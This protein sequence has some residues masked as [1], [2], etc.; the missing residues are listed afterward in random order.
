MTAAARILLV[1]DEPQIVR[2][3]TPTLKAAG[4]EV[5]CA[6]TGADALA[7]LAGQPWD[8]VLLDL[9]LPDMD[10]KAVI[11]ALRDWSDA[12]IIVL[13]ARDQEAE[14]VAALDAGADDFVNKPVGVDELLARIR[15]SL[16]SRA[17]RSLQT[18][19]FTS[20]E[21]TVNLAARRVWLD[22]DEVRLTPREYDLM[23]A[24][25]R[26]AGMV[27]T[28]A[29]IIAAVWERDAA[30]EAQHVRVLMAQLRNKIEADPSRPRLLLTEIG[31]G[32]RLRSNDDN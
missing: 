14:K 23:K 26:H 28:H 3:L 31:V 7:R 30:I 4:Y 1:D 12:P 29:Q 19:T 8:L 13:S 20:G 17:R 21:L 22:G 2:W 32:Y 6:Q 27:M 24:L 10:G 16:R 5:E 18:A 15:A 25:V 11:A 9:G